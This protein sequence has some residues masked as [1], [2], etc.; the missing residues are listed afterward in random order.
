MMLE[1]S[2]PHTVYNKHKELLQSGNLRKIHHMLLTL[3][4]GLLF[5]GQ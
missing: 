1:H 5:L 3:P 4:T 2:N